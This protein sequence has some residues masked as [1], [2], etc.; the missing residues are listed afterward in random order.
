MIRRTADPGFANEVVNH[1]DVARW[2]RGPIRGQLDLAP[3]LADKRNITLQG[4][5]GICIFALRVPGV[6][7]WHAAVRPEGH[8]RWALHAARSAV[9]WL[10]ENTAA[11]AIIAGIPQT[12]RSARYI[13]SLVGFHVKQ[14]LPSAWEEPSGERVA[15]HVYVLTRLE[16]GVQ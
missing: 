4:E 9:A 16:W 14:V 10:F 3:I 7:E 1:P 8:G 15:L 6:Y 13:V 11:V 12:N 2:V 5:H